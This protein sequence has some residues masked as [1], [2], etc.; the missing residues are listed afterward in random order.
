MLVTS[1]D[2]KSY[3][4]CKDIEENIEELTALLDQGYTVSSIELIWQ[5]RVQFVLTNNLLLKRLKCLDYLDE[6]FKDKGK[7]DNNQEQFDAN[8]SL[9]TGGL[10]DLIQFLM[11]ACRKKET[12]MVQ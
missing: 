7:L 1:G 8:F 11:D 6:A 2:D 9:L 4:T 12:V 3:Y 10:R 5:E